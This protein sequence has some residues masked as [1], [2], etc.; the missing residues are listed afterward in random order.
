M[1]IMPKMNFSEKVKKF[2]NFLDPYYL[3][4]ILILASALRLYQIALRDF[5]YDEA[6]TGVAVKE[7]FS[8]MIQ[9]IINDIHPPLYYICLKIFSAFFGYSVFGIRFF[10]A[11]LGVFSVWAVYLFAK[12]LYDKRAGLF[13]AFVVA[14]SPFAIQYSQEARMYSMLSFFLIMAA[15][16]F[17]KALKTNQAKNYILWGVFLGCACLTHYMG[18]VFSV[19][20]YLAYLVWNIFN[21]ITYGHKFNFKSINILIPTTGILFGYA[22]A[23]L[24][25]SFWIE[26]FYRHI[27]DLGDNLKWVRPANL[28][29]I[30][31]N[32]QMFL[33]GTPLG[34]MSSG[35]PNPN[36]FHYIQQTSVLSGLTVFLT[37]I[38][39]FLFAKDR[40]NTAILLV[41]SFGFFGI[42]YALSLYGKHYFVSRYLVPGAYFIFT[43]LGVW[44]S[45]IRWRYVFATLALYSVLLGFAAHLGFSTGWNVLKEN[46]T[47]YKKNNFYILTSFDYVIARYYLGEERL[48]LYNVDWP[49]YD[50]SYWAAIGPDLRRVESLNVI[51]SDPN[52]VIISN[53]PLTNKRSID[54]S[55]SPDRLELVDSYKNILVYK[56]KK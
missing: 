50:P 34:E 52:A 31:W 53:T 16:F 20:F 43:L 2:S 26:K 23:F 30:F 17:L 10:S 36:F 7:K 3:W 56:I 25:F 13:A 1:P 22:S 33:F 19:T 46:S 4:L 45:Q 9:M 55:F 54:Q 47:K 35:M 24:V 42:V 41:F 48:Y 49:A 11:I 6:F 39:V 40:K 15:Y 12:E 27:T 18:I 32:I 21:E 44:L 51:A 37:G 28:G 29:D 5:W 8:D 14:I 38:I